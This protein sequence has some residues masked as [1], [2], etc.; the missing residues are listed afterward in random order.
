MSDVPVELYRCH[1]HGSYKGVH[2]PK[3]RCFGCWEYYAM[4]HPDEPVTLGRL[5]TILG[6]VA[7]KV[8]DATNRI[9]E[10][11]LET[12][13]QLIASRNDRD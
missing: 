4:K 2:P 5:L 3:A 11:T 1:N 7:D 12:L 13:G 6:L 9:E 8:T 10:D